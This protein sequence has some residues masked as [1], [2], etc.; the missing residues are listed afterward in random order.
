VSPK[1]RAQTT[2]PKSVLYSF[3]SLSTV[4]SMAKFGKK[5]SL[6]YGVNEWMFPMM[7]VQGL[8]D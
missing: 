1:E 3:D 4:P 2:G 8:I 7:V 6:E 5:R